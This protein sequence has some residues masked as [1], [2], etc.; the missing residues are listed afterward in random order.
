MGAWGE[1][2]QANDTAL[3]AIGDLEDKV[4]N[5]DWESRMDDAVTDG[6]VQAWI[7]KNSVEDA[8][9][10]GYGNMGRLGVADFLLDHNV[11]VPI[12]LIDPAI[13]EELHEEALGCWRDSDIRREA[14]ELFRLKVIG[15]VD[16][17]SPMQELMEHHNRG[18]FTRITEDY[19]G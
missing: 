6:E 4:S 3:D 18:L 2:M 19:N 13:Q 5:R 8:L 12:E 15:E 1:G 17:D 11:Q 9:R 16:P 14:L 7:E 10:I